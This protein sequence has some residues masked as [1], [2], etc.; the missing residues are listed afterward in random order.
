M[1]RSVS[2]FI[3]AAFCIGVSG[4]AHQGAAPA[5]SAGGF[6][7]AVSNDTAKPGKATV[8]PVYSFGKIAEDGSAPQSAPVA[9]DGAIFGTTSNGGKFGFGTVFRVTSKGVETIWH[10]FNQADGSQ[11]VGNMIV[12]GKELYGTTYTGGK[13]GF[14][15]AFKISRD[16]GLHILHSFK[17]DAADGGF[18]ESGLVSLGSKF[19]GTTQ[20]GGANNGGT[21]FSVL[22]TGHEVLLHSF[23][24]TDGSDPI[25]TLVAVNGMLYGTTFAGGKFGFGTVFRAT[26]AGDVKVLHSFG[27]GADG[28]GP[29]GGLTNVNGVLYGTTGEG[30]TNGFGTI[31]KMTLA[32]KVTVL[33]DFDGANN[34]CTP[35]DSLVLMKGVLY[36]TTFGGASCPSSH[37]TVFRIT[38][39]GAE[40]TIH[41]FG[42]GTGGG[43]PYGGLGV[44]GTKLYGTTQNGGFHSQGLVFSVTR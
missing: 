26:T 6:V 38:P 35:F 14:G 43:N 5:I 41:A 16:G 4:C 3:A 25:A 24:G 23:D 27:S 33:Y 10:S 37:G 29:F 28:R 7:P 15:T 39:A 13:F 44:A 21:L 8:Q 31:F 36:G 22:T 9:F 2:G 32:G 18:I 42:G 17:D 40:T 20:G 19:Y 34:G 1:T 11:P 12:H 30:G